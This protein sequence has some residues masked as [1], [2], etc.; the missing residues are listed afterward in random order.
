M[1][2]LL[3]EKI[4]PKYFKVCLYAGVT[5][6]L[7]AVAIAVIYFSGGFWTKLWSIFKAVL[8]PIVIGGIISYLISPIVNIIRNKLFRGK[9]A[10][11]VKPLSVA[12]AFL[13]IFLIIILIV[14]AIVA[15]VNKSIVNIDIDNI[16]AFIESIQEDFSDIIAN[17]EQKISE[18]GLPVDR[19]GSFVSGFASGVKN[20]FTGL[21]FGIIFAV[22]F[23]LDGERIST[24]WKRA[25]RLIAG[26][27]A[28]AK[29]KAFAMD[30][31]MAFSGYIRGQF[32][33]ALILGAVS[34]IALTVAGIPSG[35]VVGLLMG[36]GNLI[37]YVGPIVGYASLIVVCLLQ[38]N[39][40]KLVIGLVI[41]LVLMF[42]D[43]NVL[44]PRLLANSVKVH[45]LLVVA[46]LI[47]G[48]ALGG[49]LGMLVAVPVGALI[50]LQFDR[51]LKRREES[52][53]TEN[54]EIITIDEEESK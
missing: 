20:V 37:P 30:A 49:V 14:F 42:L 7:V 33:D 2:K 1:L 34:S 3:R 40:T 27:K 17:V 52:R 36:V 35:A 50:K 31:D 48:G 46:A 32:L 15:T 23:L 51:Y 53:M 38:G 28:E 43:G 18:A 26:E 4:D 22:Y 45:P 9:E 19:I 29:I 10:S 8:S 24:Y 39:V 44:N 12:L 54:A 5:V 16:K 13:L 47:G 6:I 41:L 25:F 11:W 21:L